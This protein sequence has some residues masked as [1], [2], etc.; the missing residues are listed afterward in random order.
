MFQAQRRVGAPIGPA[1]VRD[2]NDPAAQVGQDLNQADNAT[3]AVVAQ[4]L[5]LA[6]GGDI[7]VDAQEHTLAF[8]LMQAGADRMERSRL[9]SIAGYPLHLFS[10]QMVVF[11]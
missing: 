1:K 5:V 3:E 9:K 8:D 4:D 6:G 7:Q 2:Q 10:L 11:S